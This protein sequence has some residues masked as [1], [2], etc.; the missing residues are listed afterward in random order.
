MSFQDDDDYDG[1]DDGE[2]SSDK[3]C[4]L[5]D[6]AVACV[7][8]SNSMVDTTNFIFF[9]SSITIFAALRAILEDLYAME[10][11][12]SNKNICF[13]KSVDETACF[14]WK[15][16]NDSLLSALAYLKILCMLFV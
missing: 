1:N 3:F 11:E 14:L 12:C 4:I 6:L 7:S 13:S 9:M 10:W 16:K 15:A 5:P 8:T 2:S